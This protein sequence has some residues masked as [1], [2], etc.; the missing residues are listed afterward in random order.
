MTTKNLPAV[1]FA[2]FVASAVGCGGQSLDVGYDDAR[3][4]NANPAAP[5][6][7]A[8]VKRRCDAAPSAPEPET[9]LEARRLLDGRWFL[10]EATDTTAPSAIEFTADGQWF[11][12]GADAAQVFSRDPSRKGTF[13]WGKDISCCYPDTFVL[14][15]GPDVGGAPRYFVTFAGGPLQMSWAAGTTRGGAP[16]P[17]VARYVKG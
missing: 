10:C 16:R 11:A 15:L 13:T 6:D 2:A 5:V 3:V 1:A 14:T 17:V 9:G 8:A 12:L 4:S 7:L